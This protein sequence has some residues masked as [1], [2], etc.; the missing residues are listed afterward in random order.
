MLRRFGTDDDDDGLVAPP[1]GVG[2]LEREELSGWRGG[3][4]TDVSAI[5]A[6]I[7]CFAL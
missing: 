4:S 3:G 2:L 7:C 1:P 6:P 5:D